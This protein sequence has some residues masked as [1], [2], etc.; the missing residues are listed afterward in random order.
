MWNRVITI[1]LLRILLKIFDWVILN[2]FGD[3]LNLD[4]LQF[5]YQRNCGTNMCTW[6]VIE[7]INYFQCHN[8]DVFACSMDMRKAF[9]MVKHSL[10]F[11]KLK[12]RDL[13]PIF[14]SF[15]MI[16]YI[17][18]TAVVRWKEETSK[19]FAITNGVKPF[20]VSTSMI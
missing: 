2:L 20:S 6:L 18:Q 13:P 8:S 14:L 5:S 19:P 7:S 11:T 10:L 15:L 3:K 17:N 1:D 16:A 12:D 4:E 9:D